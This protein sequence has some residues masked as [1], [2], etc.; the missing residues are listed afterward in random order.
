MGRPVEMGFG[1]ST[2]MSSPYTTPQ[3]LPQ[4]TRNVMQRFLNPEPFTTVN[5]NEVRDVT[6]I[7]PNPEYEHMDQQ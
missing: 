5:H 4:I 7:P 2:W 3:R 1:P 6:R